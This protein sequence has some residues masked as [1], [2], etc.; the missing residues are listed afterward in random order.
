MS[1]EQDSGEK[2]YEATPKK[3]EEARRKGEVPRS[4]DL[5]TAAGYGGI[6]L[7]GLITGAAVLQ[8]IGQTG[9]VLIGQADRLAPL[10][11]TRGQAP[12]GGL[13]MR[14]AEALLPFFA[15]PPLAVLGM[16]LA[17]RALIFAPEKLKP[18]ASRISP[19]SNAKNKYGR[20]GLFEFAKS[21]SKL[22]VIAIA[23]WLFLLARLPTIVAT[24]HLTPGMIGVELAR[25]VIQFLALIVAIL[26]A[27]GVVDFF[28]QRHEHFRKQRMSHK[29]LRDETKQSEGDP[30]LKNARR[31]RGQEIAGQRML[32]D[33]P[34]ADV[35]VV[36]PQ[37]YAV[38]LRWDRDGA[39][40]PV[41]VAKGV[42]EIAARIRER[43]GAAG[44]PV[45]RDPAAA[46]ALYATVDIG[47][48]ILPEHYAAVAA[49]IRFADAMRLKARAAGLR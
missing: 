41:C 12:A 44:V 36:N 26:L 4:N 33:V 20:S 13:L 25:L 21:F 40:A 31:Q 39:A 49:A 32:E 5:A 7:A 28:W 8:Q 1:E 16:L 10:V 15:I 24:L 38:A 35:V 9:T 11:L 6:L 45:H 47:A 3:L 18:K 23:L 30:H 46:R 42:D 2:E 17:Q 22:L 29:E 34:D 37:H 43:A 19:I 14:V 48:Q 27:I